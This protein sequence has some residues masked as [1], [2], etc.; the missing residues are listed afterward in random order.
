MM[1]VVF[2]QNVNCILLRTHFA[3]HVNSCHPQV[4]DTMII[5]PYNFYDFQIFCDKHI[6]FIIR[7]TLIKTA[8][9]CSVLC[10]VTH[11]IYYYTSFA[12][13]GGSGRVGER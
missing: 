12:T 13:P 11:T 10:N 9:T 2:T 4:T 5:S 3:N 7:K 6:N 1:E 8:K